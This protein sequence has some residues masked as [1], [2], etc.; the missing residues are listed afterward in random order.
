VSRYTS[1]HISLQGFIGDPAI[2]P[3]S[4]YDSQDKA[5]RGQQFLLAAF[6]L[7]VLGNSNPPQ[8]CRGL[9]FRGENLSIGI[10]QTGDVKFG[11]TL[12]VRKAGARGTSRPGTLLAACSK[13]ASFHSSD[14]EK[15]AKKENEE[16][17]QI[18]TP[19]ASTALEKDSLF[20]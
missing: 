17:A 1:R 8:G 10:C 18:D 12:S 15:S 13:F 16:V 14:A 11:F 3:R 20:P 19:G 9:Y 4:I 2:A 7:I 5:P 6:W